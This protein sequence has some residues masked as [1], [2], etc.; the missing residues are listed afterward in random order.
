MLL[1]EIEGAHRPV[2]TAFE[3]GDGISIAVLH[4]ITNITLKQI[5]H[6][7]ELL[8]DFIDGTLLI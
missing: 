4:P 1:G 2:R 7:E 3:G 8:S 5:K 6:L